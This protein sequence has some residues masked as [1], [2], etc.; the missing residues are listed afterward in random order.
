M[1]RADWY[2]CFCSRKPF[3]YSLLLRPSTDYPLFSPRF[4]ETEASDLEED[5]KEMLDL[6]R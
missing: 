6:L 5:D 1:S 3:T 2:L 4:E